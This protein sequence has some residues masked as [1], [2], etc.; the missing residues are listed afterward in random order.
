M[1]K[2]IAKLFKHDQK[3]NIEEIAK[4]IAAEIA[5]A[6]FS[7]GSTFQKNATESTAS[8][9]HSVNEFIYIFSRYL[10]RTIR[11]LKG[12]DALLAVYPCVTDYLV[13]LLVHDKELKDRGQYINYYLD[14]IIESNN[15]YSQRDDLKSLDNPLLIALAAKRITK[16]E[17]YDEDTVLAMELIEAGLKVLKLEEKILTI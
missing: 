4:N 8:L 12:R 3:S 17:T 1:F 16:S 2:S 6:S 15:Y 13:Q 7:L 5:T 9:D 11:I 14:E 10:N